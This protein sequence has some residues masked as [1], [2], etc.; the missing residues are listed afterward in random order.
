M[1]CEGISSSTPLK[2]LLLCTADL[3]GGAAESARRQ[4]EA[5]CQAGVDA[6]ML[7]LKKQ[8]NDPRITSV[9]SNLGRR[10]W[11]KFS[12]LAE[13][14][15]IYLRNGRSRRQLFRFSS[16]RFGFDLTT[17]PWV[18]DADVLHLHWINQ[19]FL[20]LSSLRRLAQLGK[21]IFVTLHD[22]WMGTGGCHLPLEFSSLGAQLCSRYALGCGL[23]PLLAS[24][25]EQDFSKSL[26]KKK[27]FLSQAPFRYIAVSTIEAQLFRQGQLMKGAPSPLVLPN[28]IDSDLFSPAS[29]ERE[30]PPAWYQAGRYYLTLVAARLD[31][32]VKGP[33][34]LKQIARHLQANYPTLAEKTTLVL[35]GGMRDVEA[36]ADLALP[37][38]TLGTIRD[39]QA[40]AK[41]YRHSSLL[42]STSLFET[43]GQTLVEALSVGTPVISFR[44]GGPEDII[45]DRENGR[46]ISPFDTKAYAEAIVSILERDPIRDS[47]AYSPKV[48]RESTRPFTA[49]AVA[50]ALIQ[51]YR[52]SL[53]PTSTSL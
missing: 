29:G 10:W 27:S 12:F 24:H 34:L 52:Q 11:G 30:E 37:Y 15:E 1:A 4:L 19:G 43:F 38:V 39:P 31:E 13:R 23:C 42:L 16:A 51:H 36:F 8:L 2:V 5:L 32:E 18:Q 53:R 26:L 40:M 17:H 7:V 22:L 35:V 21:P 20:S 45:R 47:S 33:E 9:A 14:L 46:L 3:G 44:C 50:E 48:C 6:R 41:I 49:R 25:T 28:P